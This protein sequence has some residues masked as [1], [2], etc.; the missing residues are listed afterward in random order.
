MNIKTATNQLWPTLR[1]GQNLLTSARKDLPANLHK[2][3]LRQ[4]DERLWRE[5]TPW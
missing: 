1:F 2:G 5:W 3:L 4:S